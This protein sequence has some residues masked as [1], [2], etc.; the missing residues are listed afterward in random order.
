MFCARGGLTVIRDKALQDRVNNRLRR[1]F[2]V[3]RFERR[4][5]EYQT[6]RNP[7]AARG[8]QQICKARRPFL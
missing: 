1:G 5:G 2:A 7:E 8:A 6:G 4:G 3:L